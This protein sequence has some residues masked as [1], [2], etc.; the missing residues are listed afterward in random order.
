MSLPDFGIQSI[1]VK[2]DTGAR[3]SSLHAF[4]VERFRRR[5]VEMVRFSIHPEQRS[6]R[7][8]VTVEAQLVGQRPVKPSTGQ[9]ELRLV[10]VTD[11]ELL[12]RRFPVELTL[13]R[14]DTMGFRMLLGRQAI[15]GRFVVDPGRS[16]LNGRRIKGTRRVKRRS[17]ESKP[18]RES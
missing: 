1:K 2:V 13:T 10:V 11:A 14:R 18:A 15:R 4:D 17:S 9:A 8:A 12:G 16:F 6:G 7:H 3:T 5:G